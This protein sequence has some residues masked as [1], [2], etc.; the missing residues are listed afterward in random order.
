MLKWLKRLGIL[1]GLFLILASLIVV[2]GFRHFSKPQSGGGPYAWN[3]EEVGYSNLGGRAGFKMAMQKS[4]EKWY[5]YIAHFWTRGWSVVDVTDPENP[6]HVIYIEGPVNTSTS[7][8]QVADGLMVT[9]LERPI[10]ELVD[11]M[12]WQMYAWAVGRTLMG[13]PLVA[14]GVKYDEGI[15]LWDVKDPVSPRKLHQWKT[16]NTGT[17]RNYYQGGD[18]LWAAGHMPGFIGHQIIGLD[19]SDPKEPKELGTFVFGEQKATT[20]DNPSR[21]KDGF[22]FH[23]PLHIEGNRGYASYGIKGGLILDVSDPQNLELLGS[24][25]PFPGLGSVQGVHSF[26]PLGDRQVAVMSTEAHDEHCKP[27]PGESYTVIVDISDA[28]NPTIISRFPDPII[29]DNAPFES[30]CDR[31]GRSGVHNQHHHNNQSH[32]YRSDRFV[33]LAKFNEGVRL[34]DT[35]D[36]ENVEEIGYF[37]PPD[38]VHRLGPMPSHLV[39]QTEDV[40]VDAR[41]YVYISDKNQGLRILKVEHETFRKS[42]SV[43]P[44]LTE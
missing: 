18:H 15:I 23:G 29:P 33:F 44:V 14:P 6:E 4:G 10:Y 27:D 39:A 36:P 16:G 13:K 30:F 12:P 38:P 41:G 22:Y 5:L 34:Y 37:V 2:T 24:V 9:S 19:I 25:N 26:L 7:N 28:T 43:H 1:L 31:P 11:H 3:I 21:S 35:Q 40:I 32:L 8:I 17:H 20:D 42:L